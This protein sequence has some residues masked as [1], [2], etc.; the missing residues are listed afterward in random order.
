M[1][2][3]DLDVIPLHSNP[4]GFSEGTTFSDVYVQFK[5][6]VPRMQ[7]L[8]EGEPVADVPPPAVF[9]ILLNYYDTFERG[10]FVAHCC[11]Q[12][13]MAPFYIRRVKQLLAHDARM[14]L[15]DNGRQHVHL[16][17]NEITIVKPFR[18]F[19]EASDRNEDDRNEDDRDDHAYTICTELHIH[20][21]MPTQMC[22][23][24]WSDVPTHTY[25]YC[26]P[27]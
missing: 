23:V 19:R 4:F 20:V 21:H 15:L 25:V 11:T 7:L 14:H 17:A 18:I 27:I 3:D 8:L 13:A 26:L 5:L 10:L 6:D 9:T 24:E 12:T 2:V 1:P 22:I 16:T